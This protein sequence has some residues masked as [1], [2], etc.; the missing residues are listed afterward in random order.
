M[1]IRKA[2]YGRMLDPQ[3]KRFKIGCQ[4]GDVQNVAKVTQELNVAKATQKLNV[5]KATRSSKYD[6]SLGMY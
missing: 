5:A 3:H 6:A 2:S 1:I 4:P